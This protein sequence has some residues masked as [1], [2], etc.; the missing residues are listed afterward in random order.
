MLEIDGDGVRCDVDLAT[1]GDLILAGDVRELGRSANYVTGRISRRAGTVA[2]ATIRRDIRARARRRAPGLASRRC[3][4]REHAERVVGTDINPHALSL[5][6]MNQ[7]LNAVSNA[8]WV[9]GNWFE[10]ARWRALRSRRR[11]PARRDLARQRRR[12]ARQRDRGSGVC[13][14]DGKPGRRSPRGRRL[15]HRPVQLEPST[16]AAGTTRLA[17]GWPGSTAMPY[18]ISFGSQDPLVYAMSNLARPSPVGSRP[19]GRDDQALGRP[20]PKDRR[21]ADRGRRGRP[22]PSGRRSTLGPSPSSGRR[23]QAARAATSSSGCSPAG[24][25]S[26]S[27]SEPR[28][29]ARP[30]VNSVAPRGRSPPGT[31]AGARGRGLRDRPGACSGRSPACACLRRVDPRVVPLI[32]AC[33]GR[34]PARSASSARSRRPRDSSR[35]SSSRSASRP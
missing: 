35:P 16:R 15:C 32:D 10:P 21:G 11:Q 24:T 1:I 26:T 23:A 18:V 22:T 5:A 4:P 8:T 13:R 20:L 33:D 19:R 25:S 3:S 12:R 34:R 14:P 9:E 17:S 6:S 27:R 2:Y 7:H 29:L 30:A 31:G 28:G